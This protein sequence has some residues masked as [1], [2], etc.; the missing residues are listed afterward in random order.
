MSSMHFQGVEFKILLLK[1][2]C[3]QWNSSRVSL[4]Y[5]VAGWWFW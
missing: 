5:V 4:C 2:C 1:S 3:S